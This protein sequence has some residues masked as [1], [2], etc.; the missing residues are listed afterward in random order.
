MQ[1]EEC[2]MNQFFFRATRKCRLL[3]TCLWDYVCEKRKE[4]EDEAYRLNPV[5]WSPGYIRA[6]TACAD[7]AL[8]DTALS[9]VFR[10][11]DMRLPRGYGYG[12]DERV[13]EW[14]WTLSRLRER[15]RVLDAGS[16]LNHPFILNRLDALDAQLDIFTFAP[17]QVC[18]W[19]RGISYLFGDIRDL[20]YKN[21]FFDVVVSISTLEH[22][23]MDNSLYLN[24]A[25]EHDLS[26]VFSAIAEIRRV[27]KDN[28]RL[29]F[30]VPFGRYEDHKTFQQFNS[31]LLAKCRKAFQPVKTEEAFFL[32]SQDGWQRATE[33]D[34]AAAEYAGVPGSDNAAAARAVACCVWWK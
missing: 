14:P 3:A 5:P 18:E 11:K 32:Y 26:A 17:E 9:A 30:S 15:E 24:D 23:G 34:C 13:V 29:I 1:V 10:G 12:L 2:V 31:A 25:Q 33:Q 22:I 16:A 28:G 21:S 20:P 19:K 6:R 8:S 27:L 4:D 7:S